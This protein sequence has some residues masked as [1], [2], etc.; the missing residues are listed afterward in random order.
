VIDLLAALPGDSVPIDQLRDA[1][2]GLAG[3]TGLL[4]FPF[5]A[6]WIRVLVE[7]IE[8]DRTGLNRPRRMSGTRVLRAIGL[9]VL[10][11]FFALTT[12]RAAS[13]L[14]RTQAEAPVVSTGLQGIAV[15]IAFWALYAV[16]MTTLRRDARRRRNEHRMGGLLR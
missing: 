12:F 10:F 1:V 15:G 9:T 5:F 8:W 2:P 3:I 13:D 16:G 4:L 11:T 7:S 14:R 6:A